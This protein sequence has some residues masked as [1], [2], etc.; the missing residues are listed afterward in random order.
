MFD[1]LFTHPYLLSTP[2]SSHFSSTMSAL[3]FDLRENRQKN[4]FDHLESVKTEIPVTS[5]GEIASSFTSSDARNWPQWR[6]NLMI[7]MVSFHSMTSVFMAAGI[8]P[9]TSTMAK[10]YGVLL[11]DASYLVSVQVSLLNVQN[12]RCR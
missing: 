2:V 1:F 10:S 4:S 6:K 11:A 12:S 7:I 9:A 3:S 5:E 8:V